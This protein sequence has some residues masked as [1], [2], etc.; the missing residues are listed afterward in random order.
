MFAEILVML[1][2]IKNCHFN[3]QDYLQ[4]VQALTLQ[5][6]N[7]LKQWC[8]VKQQTLERFLKQMIE[9]LC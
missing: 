5:T 2:R 7:I 4:P 3:Y 1:K 8:E 6:E 9:G